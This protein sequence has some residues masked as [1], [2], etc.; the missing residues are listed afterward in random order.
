MIDNEL[1]KP[2]PQL[3]KGQVNQGSA[4]GIDNQATFR[5]LVTETLAE[6]MPSITAVYLIGIP[7]FGIGTC[8]FRL[9]LVRGQCNHNN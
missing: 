7:I 9:A 4:Q 3:Q 5:L 6:A 8:P 1:L 2:E